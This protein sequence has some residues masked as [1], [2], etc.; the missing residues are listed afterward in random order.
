MNKIDKEMNGKHHDWRDRARL[1]ERRALF[2]LTQ[3]EAADL[4]G[5]TQRQWAHYEA[6]TRGI[7]YAIARLFELETNRLLSEEIDQ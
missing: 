5:V 6:G 1:A 4:V 2:N 7:P 3:R